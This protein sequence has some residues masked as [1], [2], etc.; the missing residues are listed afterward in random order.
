[1]DDET[2]RPG[3]EAEPEDGAGRERP[4]VASEGRPFGVG[5]DVGGTG[6][7]AAVVDLE[8]GS[9]VSAR[10]REKTPSP[11]TPDAV[12]EAV[13]RLIEGIEASGH[14]T[15]GMPTGAGLPGVAK[16][17]WLR[18]AANIDDSWLKV[19]AQDVLE[20]HLDR[21][22][23]IINDADAAGL[24]EMRYGAGV[25]QH[26]VVL[27]LTIGTGIGSALFVDDRLVPNTEFGHLEFHRRDAET[28]VSGAARERRKLGWKAWAREFDQYLDRIYR[29][30]SP[31]LVILG[32]GVSKETRRYLQYLT[33]RGPLQVARLLN[34]AGIVGAALAAAEAGGYRP[35]VSAGAG[36]VVAAG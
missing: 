35:P 1:M 15:K 17:G 30:F 25:G 14:R 3:N 8:T 13:A 16:D 29:Y 32:G 31:D 9:L 6:V 12:A 28:L 36:T 19:R 26:G 5:I 33:P 21:P 23:V 27:M 2:A 22:V 7:K 18:T 4:A 34:S 20:Q 11:S 10:L 24:A